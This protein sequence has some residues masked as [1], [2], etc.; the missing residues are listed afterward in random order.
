M[1]EKIS[2]RDWA[3]AE[4]MVRALLESQPGLAGTVSADG[5]TGR[6][7]A[8]FVIGFIDEYTKLR[9]ERIQY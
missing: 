7:L 5:S 4:T 6:D 3:T 8:Q 9:K 2:E 1:A